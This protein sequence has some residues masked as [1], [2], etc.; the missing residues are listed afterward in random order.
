MGDLVLGDSL[1]DS[2]DELVDLSLSPEHGN[3]FYILN[4]RIWRPI[5]IPSR[6]SHKYM[7]LGVVG[8]HQLTLPV[9]VNWA[10]FT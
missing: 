9:C 8:A 7:L 6:M 5:I 4:G 1:V 2:V 10:T 3:I